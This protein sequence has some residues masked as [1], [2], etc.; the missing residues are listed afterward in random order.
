VKRVLVVNG[1][2]LD[3]LGTRQPELYG[4]QTL[5]DLVERLAGWASRLDLVV[6]HFQS[7]HEG[8]L[9]ERV[10]A[11]KGSHD[12]IVINAGALTHYSRGLADALA[13]VELPV[14]EVHISNVMERE[15]WRRHSV[16]A[17]VAVMSIYGRGLNGYRWA[18]RHLVNRSRHPFTGLAYGPLPDQTGQ[19]RRPVAGG[20]TLII[21]V[22]GG[23]WR[24]EWTLDTIESLAV[25]LTLQGHVT[26]N[27][28]Y[29]RVGAGGGW[30]ESFDDLAA[31]LAASPS[32]TG[33]GTE[34]TVVMGHSA[35]GTMAMW[36][37]ALPHGHRPAYTVGLAPITD[38]VRADD[39]Q[40]GEA[41]VRR[42]LGRQRRPAPEMYSPRHRF[43]TGP[44][45]VLAG[46]KD[47]LVPLDY[48][49]DY[50]SAASELGSEVEV[51]E[52][53]SDHW[54]FLD[55]SQA[56]WRTVSDRLRSRI[57]PL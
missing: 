37:G 1:P 48:A 46:Q 13:A 52:V 32:L 25:D 4:H 50:L 12:A 45:L 57:P 56:H 42:L 35:G 3:L 54:S 11:A 40:L 9:I 16:L 47:T 41:T 38:L 26:W 8:A 24:H 27:L 44:G 21:L 34:R 31:A 10:H 36:A 55:P 15:P 20:S 43:P 39:E 7:N 51:I 33:I 49:R 22:H 18:L 2:N 53:Q 14:V 30:P 23:L 19:L 29:R 28:E 17:P 5:A 6:D